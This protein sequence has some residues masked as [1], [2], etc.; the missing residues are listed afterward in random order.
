MEEDIKLLKEMKQNCLAKK[1]YIDPKAEIKAQA[2]ENVLNRLEQLEKENAELKAMLK[3][4]IKYTQ[5]LEKDLFENASHYVV[6]KSVI[7]EKIEELENN[8]KMNIMARS[9]QIDILKE[10]LE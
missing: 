7:R 9:S 5:E 6:P 3:N 1:E 10:I 2:I 4:R 8:R